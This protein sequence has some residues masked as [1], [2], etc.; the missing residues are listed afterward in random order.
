VT[1]PERN[2][3]VV[4]RYVGAFNR[5]DIPVLRSLFTPDAVIHGVLGSG[6]MGVAIP[7]WTQLHASL[8]LTLEVQS[9]VAEGDSAAS[10]Y[11]ERGTFKALFLGHQPT[12]RSFELVAME[13]F[14]LRDGLIAARWGARDSAAMARQIGL[15]LV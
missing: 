2:K 5:L 1:E 7:I 8:R 14:V 13:W 9:M 10:R 15:P 6:G 11:I 3:A 4:L 12:G